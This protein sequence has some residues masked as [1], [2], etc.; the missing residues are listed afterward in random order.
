MPPTTTTTRTTSWGSCEP[1]E[2]A[3]LIVKERAVAACLSSLSSSL[4]SGAEVTRE[5]AS[6]VESAELVGAS[7]NL[8]SFYVP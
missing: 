2:A 8:A 1:I 5:E 4:S 7:P 3:I 6:P